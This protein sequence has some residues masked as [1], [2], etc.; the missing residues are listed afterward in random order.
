MCACMGG[1]LLAGLTTWPDPIPHGGKWS[2]YREACALHRG[3][4]V[5]SHFPPCG[6]V[7]PR[8]ALMMD[9]WFIM[10]RKNT[11]VPQVSG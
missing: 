5:Q 3:V 4:R 2:S 8:E 10:H 7:W 6:I 1:G 9:L 11:W